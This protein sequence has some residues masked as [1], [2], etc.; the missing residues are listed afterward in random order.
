MVVEWNG[1]NKPDDRMIFVIILNQNTVCTIDFIATNSTSLS[2]QWVA[3][4]SR[5][6]SEIK[7][8]Q[9]VK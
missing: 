9:S 5:G 1:A 7:N 8:T 3:R 4:I 6:T 2:Q